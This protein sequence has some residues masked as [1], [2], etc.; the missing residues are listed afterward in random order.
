MTNRIYS[1]KIG[2]RI[3]IGQ[4]PVLVKNIEKPTIYSVLDA[5]YPS[6]RNLIHMLD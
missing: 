3:Y 2:R 1:S 6:Q 4:V 5:G